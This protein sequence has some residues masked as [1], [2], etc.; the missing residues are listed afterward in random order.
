MMIQVGGTTAAGQFSDIGADGPQ[1][2]ST[3]EPF[4]GGKVV[5]FC[6]PAAFPP[7]CSA[8]GWHTNSWPATWSLN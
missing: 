6:V 3:N 5:L 2:K 1:S 8:K 7:V 4:S